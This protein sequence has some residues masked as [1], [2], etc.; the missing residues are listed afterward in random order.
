MMNL[1]KNV[2]FTT[3]L[4]ASVCLPI[5]VEARSSLL[6]LE[7]SLLDDLHSELYLVS[8]SSLET[9]TAAVCFVTDVSDCDGGFF[10]NSEDV[11]TGGNPDN[12]NPDNDNRCKK[13]GYTIKSCPEGYKLGGLKCPYDD[14]YTKCI[15]T[16]PSNYVECTDPYVGVGEACEGKYASCSCTPCASEYSNTSIPS[17]YLQDGEACL[18]CDG[19]KKYK[20]K[21]NPCN[22]FMDCGDLGGAAGAKTCQSGNKTKYD[23]CKPCP[24]LG[25]YSSC[26]EGAVCTR[27]DCSGLW[28]ITGCQSGYQF[29]NTTSSCLKKCSTDFR[30]VCTGTG[31]AGGRGEKC[32]GKY[33]ECY[34]DNGYVWSNGYCN[35]TYECLIGSILYSDKTCSMSLRSGKTPI[36]I[37]VYLDGK[38]GGQA[39]ALKSS[40]NHKWGKNGIDI[41]G[42]KN[43]SSASEAS[44]DF[45]SCANSKIIMAAGNSSTY[46]AVWV[47]NSYS[48]V[49]T[50]AGDWCLPAAGV[51][52]SYY[53]NE[54]AVNAGFDRA[55]GSKFVYN[56]YAGSSTEHSSNHEWG[57]RFNTSYGLSYSGD[58]GTNPKEGLIEVR[59]VLEF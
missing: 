38:G 35:E 22:G 21:I 58:Y 9:K 5:S 10:S 17:G 50:K 51:F 1:R 7:K 47:A 16:C 55:G 26:P 14:Y 57:A 13:E 3:G 48:T 56:T 49:G 12:F 33:A 11:D 41:S 34:C 53:N 8:T 29:D 25:K 6:E 15:P 32:D 28:Y 30:Y 52:T 40:G 27:E 4:L 39:L 46:P 18:D 19:Q 36:A 43:Y 54:D 37:V 23:N 24:N 44:Q 45:A 59:P 20:I 2:V 31:Y 42:L